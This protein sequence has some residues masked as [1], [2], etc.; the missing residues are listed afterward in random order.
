MTEFWQHAASV[1]PKEVGKKYPPNSDENHVKNKLFATI[2]NVQVVS[3]QFQSRIN[4][5]TA[6]SLDAAF[7][8]LDRESI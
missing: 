3:T 7:R 4:S 2:F 6:L 1:K 5:T 8:K